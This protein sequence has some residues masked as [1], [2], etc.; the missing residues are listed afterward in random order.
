VGMPLADGL[1]LVHGSLLG[2]Q[3]RGKTRIFA[4][5]KVT[6]GFDILRLIALGAD[7]C[8]S[9]R[10]MMF[11]LGCIQALKCNTNK[12]PTGVATSNPD[13]VYGLVPE[14]KALRVQSFHKKTVK[15]FVEMLGA[16]GLY[17]PDD[18]GMEH[19]MRRRSAGQLVRLSEIY[20][21]FVPGGLLHGEV[22]DEYRL[23]WMRASVDGFRD[24]AVPSRRHA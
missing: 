9:A 12:C 4:S 24:G 15:S 2:A 10:A 3:L 14:E 23:E 17:H 11:A 19:V 22:P 8:N 13:L 16:A 7:A 18:L 6:N 21:Q 5:G 20:P 1:A